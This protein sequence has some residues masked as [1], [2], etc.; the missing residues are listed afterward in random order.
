MK[1]VIKKQNR[2]KVSPIVLRAIARINDYE[3][4][5]T[6][7]LNVWNQKSINYSSITS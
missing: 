3:N 7:Y 5:R 1:Y 4:R 6:N 2:K